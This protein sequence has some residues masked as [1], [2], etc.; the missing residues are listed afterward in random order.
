MVM[1]TASCKI[2]GLAKSAMQQLTMLALE[3]LS[4]VRNTVIVTAIDGDVETEIFRGQIVNSWPD[5]SGAPDVYLHIEAQAGFFEQTAL[6]EPTSYKGSADAGSILGRLASGLGYTFENNGVDVKLS[7][8]Y[9]AGSAMEQVKEIVQAAG[10]EWILDGQTLAIWPKGATRE[11]Y[12]PTISPE[13]GLIGYPTFDQLG[14][15]FRTLFNPSIRFGGKINVE[16]S[17]TRAAGV[18]KVV[19]VSHSLSAQM[20]GGPWYSDI[21]CTES[22]LVPVK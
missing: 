12:M 11:S 19:G 3:T 14:V 6:S 16:T 7:D 21:R 17:V 22:G 13:T 4:V 18:R 1:S 8:P 9:F 15:G 2:Y 20:P 5:Y 10:I